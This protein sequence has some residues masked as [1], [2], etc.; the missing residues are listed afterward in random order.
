[1]RLA[2]AFW[3][4]VDYEDPARTAERVRGVGVR[5]TVLVPGPQGWT[6]EQIG[7]VREAFDKAGVFVAEVA[8]Y[9][10]SWIASRDGRRRAEGIASVLKSIQDA[11]EL[12]AH[13]VGLGQIAD[14]DRWSQETWDLLVDGTEQVA[15]EAERLGV[16][17]AFHPNKHSP[18]DSPE[19][20]R[21]L[22]D[23]VG[24]ARVKVMLD[25]VNMTTH[26]TFDDM[27]GYVD[28]REHTTDE[29]PEDHD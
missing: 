20:L 1:M 11:K 4:G 19:Q 7:R 24:S 12:D 10:H 13:C 9:R 6:K 27:T 3:E 18:L 16:D 2:V 22:I 28:F 14:R 29:E 5:G 8:Q 21:R 23:A 25:L 17:V 26:R 15:V